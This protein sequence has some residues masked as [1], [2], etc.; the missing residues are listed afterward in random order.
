MS[1][2]RSR[3]SSPK[4][5]RNTVSQN[6]TGRRSRSWKIPMIIGLAMMVAASGYFLFNRYIRPALTNAHSQS[7]S[8]GET[9]KDIRLLRGGEVRPTLEPFLFRGKVAEAYSIA[10]GNRELLDSIYC[11]CHC[12]RNLGHKSLLTCFVDTHALECEICQDQ[13][14]FAFSRYKD[15][16]S[17]RQVRKAV[18]EKF[19]RPFS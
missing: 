19:W 14:I 9:E 6:R 5:K 8:S 16:L 13:A 3:K 11:Y 1:R 17:F 18:D 12:E 10:K 15:G 7:A 4:K 2:K